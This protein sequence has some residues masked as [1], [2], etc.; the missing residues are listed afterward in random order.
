MNIQQAKALHQS[1]SDTLGLGK[2]TVKII[3]NGD[4]VCILY[5]HI[6]IWNKKDWKKYKKGMSSL[7]TK[8][9]DN[10]EDYKD[11]IEVK[12]NVI[13]IMSEQDKQESTKKMMQTIIHRMIHE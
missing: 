2:V 12:V 13:K 1:I 6:F 4:Y 3:G 5:S 11:E 10:D 7:L 8:E 9:I